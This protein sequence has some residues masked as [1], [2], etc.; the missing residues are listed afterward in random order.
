MSKF[1]WNIQAGFYRALRRNPVSAGIL[2][3]ENEAVSFLLKEFLPAPVQRGLDIG[4]GSG[5]SLKLIPSGEAGWISLDYSLRMIRKSRP[6]FK[7][8]NFVAGDASS[9]PFKT[10]SFDLVLCIGVAEYFPDID[11]FL[12]GLNQILIP[13]GFVVLTITPPRVLNILRKIMGHWFY[14]LTR[15]ELEKTANRNSF[16]IIQRTCTTIQEQYLLQKHA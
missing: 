2:R 9:L 12:H 7:H 6:H 11:P 13:E 16:N 1:L 5:N 8:M 14:M 10:E 3:Q 4:S 15:E